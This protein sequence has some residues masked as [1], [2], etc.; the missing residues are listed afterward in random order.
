MLRPLL[1]AVLFCLLPSHPALAADG[2]LDTTFD[3]DGMVITDF[4]GGTDESYN[5]VIQSDGKIVV[6][7]KAS[8]DFALARY[9][10]DGSLDSTFDGDGKVTTAF[11]GD[12]FGYG[13]ALQSDGKIMVAGGDDSGG[14]DDFGLARYNSDG[15]LDTTFDGDGKVTTD[16]AA[17]A[18]YAQDMAIQPDGKMVLVGI[19]GNDFAVARYNTDGSL[20]T[21]FDTDGM[22]TTDFGGGTDLALHLAFQPDGKIVVAGRNDIGGAEDFAVARYN[23]DGSLDTTFSTDGKVTTNFGG[24]D[25]GHGVSIQADGKIVVVGTGGAVGD[26]A[27]A[28]YNSDGSLDSTFD[29]DGKVTTDFG[30][31][32]EGFGGKIQADGKIVVAGL[33]GNDFAVARYDTDGS[34]DTTF[35]TDGKVITD[36][37][38]GSDG[39]YG[40]ALQ[41]DG[42]IVVAGFAGP[43]FG[44]VRYDSSQPGVSASPDQE[45]NRLVEVLACNCTTGNATELVEDYDLPQNF[46]FLCPE[47]NVYE[48]KA[49]CN[50]V[51]GATVL[52]FNATCLG[53]AISDLR[54][55]KIFE[56]NSTSLDFSTYAASKTTGTDGAWWVTDAS[57]TYLNATQT[58]V[59]GTNYYVNFVVKDNGNYDGDATVGYIL[60]PVALGT[61][62]DGS[63]R[64]CTLGASAGFSME[65]VLLLLGSLVALV[66]RRKE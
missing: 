15:S 26:F 34:L 2:D 47:D 23:T 44:V 54:L 12:D 32:D 25:F 20:D 19:A 36:I 56:T 4:V 1:L 41:S 3:G 40:V 61:V 42:K 6:V 14:A 62:S 28:R 53:G 5:V 29:G 8:N 66:R 57:N 51:G 39:G 31:T 24:D 22:L 17:G 18:A 7:G 45:A 13:V 43:D 52:R 21:T 58:L 55:V 50:S 11:G 59:S 64:G 10:S 30:G 46:S 63:A 48:V 9:N 27:V 65:L 37:T 60:D 16:F 33:S 38:G 49:S 35:S